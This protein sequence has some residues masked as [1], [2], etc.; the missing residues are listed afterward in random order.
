MSTL[1]RLARYEQDFAQWA[2]DSAQAIREHQLDCIEWEAVA[3]ELE[4]LARKERN[5]LQSRLAQLIYHLLKMEYQPGRKTRS[6]EATIAAQRNEL[7]ELLVESPS[8]GRYLND[9]TFLKK[10]YRSA[11]A[12]AGPENLPDDVFV[13]FPKTC[14]Y[15]I[16]V[17]LPETI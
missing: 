5:E 1:A 12:L 11:I 16:E 8:L 9:P 4:Y 10:T 6:W 3:E 13:H 15:T 7:N 17:L 14:P 2:S